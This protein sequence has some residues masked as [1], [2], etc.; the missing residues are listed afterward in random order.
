MPYQFISTGGCP[1]CD[2]MAGTYA[3]MPKRPHPH[4]DCTIK[5][6]PEGIPCFEYRYDKAEV[7]VAEVDEESGYIAYDVVI[8]YTITCP[9]IEEEHNL[10]YELLLNH[11]HIGMMKYNDTDNSFEPWP[12]LDELTQDREEA[13][14]LCKCKERSENVVWPK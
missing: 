1:K 7:S 13:I 14:K 4:C 5:Q 12:R 3:D 2:A 6:L 9:E 11:V 8:H 10:T